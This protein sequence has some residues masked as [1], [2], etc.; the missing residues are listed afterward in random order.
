VFAAASL[1]SCGSTDSKPFP[2]YQRGYDAGKSAELRHL[3][4]KG[5]PP[6][7][8]C[9]DRMKA[10]KKFQNYTYDDDAVFRQGCLNAVRDQGIQRDG[11]S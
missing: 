8:A 10:D 3:I 11:G 7:S 1:I 9:D 6:M 4:D 5:E 2:A